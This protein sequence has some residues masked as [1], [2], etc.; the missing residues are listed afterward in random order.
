MKQI[1]LALVFGLIALGLIETTNAM[2]E[3]VE[4]IGGTQPP[5]IIPPPITPP[6]ESATQVQ[7]ETS[8]PH[9]SMKNMKPVFEKIDLIIKSKEDFRNVL[10]NMESVANSMDTKRN[11]VFRAVHHSKWYID[12]QKQLNGR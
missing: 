9:P 12:W 8:S 3:P 4:S 2:S 1:A 11:V 5:I 6:S 7:P 10:Q